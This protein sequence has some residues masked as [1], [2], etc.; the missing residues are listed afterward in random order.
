M[1]VG[2]R[3]LII[4]VSLIQAVFFFCFFVLLI[5][6]QNKEYTSFFYIRDDLLLTSDHGSIWNKLLNYSERISKIFPLK[7]QILPHKS[8]T[9][10]R[11]W[12]SVC[13]S[14]KQVTFFSFLWEIHWFYISYWLT[15]VL[16][17]AIMV[18]QPVRNK[19]TSLANWFLNLSFLTIM[20]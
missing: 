11:K 9:L 10:Q 4:F 1:S 16:H 6:V 7:Y 12:N 5:S 14:R 13:I 8:I 20:N 15:L 2:E 3:M 19:F 17:K 18:E